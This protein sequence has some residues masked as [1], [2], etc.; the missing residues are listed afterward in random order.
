MNNVSAAAI[1][2]LALALAS[3][4]VRAESK[5]GP[6]ASDT[7]VKIGQ[8]MPFS[9]PLA[10]LSVEGKVE[11][12]YIQ[13]INEKGGVGGRKIT[14][15]SRDDAYSPAKAVEQTRKL[16]EGDEVLAMFGSFGTSTNLA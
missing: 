10:A 16:V 11:Q 5:Y 14:L 8:T 2:A 9:G 3:T 7:E 6:A 15:L 13:M 1:G 12:A 4:P